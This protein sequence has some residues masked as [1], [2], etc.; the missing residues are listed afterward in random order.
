MYGDARTSSSTTTATVSWTISTATAAC[1]C[2]R[3]RGHQQAVDRV[4]S[5]NPSLVGGVG[6]YSACCGHGPVHAHRRARLPRA[7]ARVWKWVARNLGSR[8]EAVVAAE[9]LCPSCGT[10][11]DPSRPCPACGA[12]AIKPG[13]HRAR[14]EEVRDEDL[15]PYVTLRYIARLF[16]VLA[17]LMVIM[18]IGEVVTGLA[19]EG[20]AALMT[21]IGEATKLLVIGGLMWA[22]GDITVPADRRRPRSARRAHPPRPHQCSAPSR[23]RAADG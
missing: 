13:E 11:R 17:I 12:P 22:G 23:G 5:K 15:E 10:K 18:L 4:E 7:M 14:L 20:G 8:K 9:V 1:R 6:V 21:L 16:K 3:R 19:T 2:A